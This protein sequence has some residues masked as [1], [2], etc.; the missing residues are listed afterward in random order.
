M[1]NDDVPVDVS[2][3]P[4]LE[5]VLYSARRASSFF[6]FFHC[7]Q[8]SARGIVRFQSLAPVIASICLDFSVPVRILEIGPVMPNHGNQVS[9][10]SCVAFVEI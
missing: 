3:S 1:P 5:L 4:Q 2:V 9:G 10:T 8:C 7:S 6:F